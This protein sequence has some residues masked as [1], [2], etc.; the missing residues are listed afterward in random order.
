PARRARQQGGLARADG[1]GGAEGGAEIG[2]GGDGAEPQVAQAVELE[3]SGTGGAALGGG[4]GDGAVAGVVRDGGHDRGAVRA[5]AR[6]RTRPPRCRRAAP[7]ER[8]WRTG[9]SRRS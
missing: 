6:P 7:S 2:G 9:P 4:D 8:G 1:K 3:R 5:H